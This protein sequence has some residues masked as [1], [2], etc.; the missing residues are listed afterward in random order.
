MR[1]VLISATAILL[2][3]TSGFVVAARA[4]DTP[5]NRGELT[6]PWD[7]FK[8]LVNLEAD[9][10]IISLETFQKLLVQAGVPKAP[11]HAFKNGNV[12]MTRDEFDKLVAKMKPP[13]G[14][15]IA[16]PFDHLIT[17]AVYSG[18]MGEHSTAFTAVFTVHVLKRDAFVKVAI[19][20]E[21]VALAD[22]QVGDEPAL[23]VR[24][25]G[26]HKVV[27]PR[28]GEYN[29]TA[30][31]SVKSSLEKGPHKIDLSIRETPI[32]LLRLQMPMKDL[33]VEIPQAQQVLA[34]YQDNT[35]VVSAVIGQGSAVSVRWKKKV[36][37]AEK[38]PPKLYS[39]VHHLIS[40]QDGALRTH[41]D[42]NYTI[43]HS[44]VDI[45]RVVL[46]EGMNVLT[47]S[48]EGVGEWQ[49]TTQEGQRILLIPLTYGKKGTT[50][51][52]ITTE[53]ALSE[54]GLANAFAG[55]RTLDTVRETG[56]IGLELAT[57]AEVIVTENV[58]LE[59][60]PV[61]KL[62]PPLVDKSARPLIAGFKYLKHPYSLV[63]DVKKHDKIAVPVATI[64]SASVVTL[65]T[66]D[67]KVVNRL[68]YKMKNS[69]KQFLEIQLPKN[70]DVWSVFVDN[71][72]VESSV[73]GEGKL[74]V[75]LIRSLSVN[76]RLDS[77]PVEVVYCT[78]R[79][80]FSPFGSQ[81]TTLPAVDV[82]VS[83]LMWSVYLP[84]DYSYVYFQSSLEKEEMIRGVNLFTGA[85]RKYD[86]S[87]MEDVDLA[88]PGRSADEL[89]KIYQGKGYRSEFRN[90]PMEQEELDGQLNAELE[91][92]GR[93]EALVEDQAMLRPGSG[94]SAATG[95]MPIQIRVPT[96]GQVYRFAKTIIRPDDPLTFSVAYTQSW[97]VTLFK[98]FVFAVVALI[99]Y[100]NRKR[101]VRTGRWWSDKLR[102]VVARAATPPAAGQHGTPQP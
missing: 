69:A 87:A 1:Q 44:E 20:P 51:V 24:E 42:I 91:F 28:T 32:T 5:D 53:T 56:F 31:Y 43:L 73:N 29:I 82:L 60:V 27:L 81:E 16:P 77:F 79:S 10:I 57:S 71:E 74:L 85:L 23:V 80:R 15:D 22:M 68:V 102:A 92:G 14:P 39:E 101:L 45:V 25:D 96:G 55:I 6:V 90:V 89:K 88:R 17:K 34:S 72:P 30:S 70:A 78:V 19:L 40:I 84:N 7:E 63:F 8:K 2:L 58:G 9:E 48:G 21:S 37:A 76:D 75:P 83:Q 97:V 49:E 95:V 50:T 41:S 13:V 4:Q 99:I 3:I 35:T 59:K 65:F 46:P 54:A 98:W 33:D 93:L 18:T 100:L 62:P 36:A 47:V 38:I 67:G 61:Q 94:G 64:N 52:R 66:E 11:P 86:K 12:V 26:Y